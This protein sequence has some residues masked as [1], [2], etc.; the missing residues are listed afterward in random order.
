MK[1]ANSQ[2][3][4]LGIGGIGMSGIAELLHKM[5]ATVSGTDMKENEQTKRLQAMGVQIYFGHQADNIQNCDVVVYSS[6]VKQDN[7]EMLEAK[8]R[9][10]PRIPRAEALAEIMNL[11]RGLA[12]AGT[13]GKTTTTSFVSSVFVHAKLEPTIAV[14]GRLDLIKYTAL[15]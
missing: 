10:I 1:F 5:G 3:H 6:A 9:F 7:P 13:H 15:L 12:I 14:G 2:V 8:R 4:F 11:K